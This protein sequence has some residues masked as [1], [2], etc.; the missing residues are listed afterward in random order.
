M[1]N[2]KLL[3]LMFIVLVPHACASEKD[4]DWVDGI[5]ETCYFKDDLIRLMKRCGRRK[6]ETPD[7]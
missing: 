3:F 5:E 1:K 2:V 6:C 4:S 7:G